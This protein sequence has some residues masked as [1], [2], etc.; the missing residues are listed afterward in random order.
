MTRHFFSR[1]DGS[2]LVTALLVMSLFMSLGVATLSL[3]DVQQKE[4]G[5]ERVRESAFALS[6]G[7]LNSQ[8]YLLSRQWPG[9][10]AQAYVGQC[11]VATSA[12]ARCPD[13]ATM[14]TGF[15]GSDYAAGMTWTTEVR[16]NTLTGTTATANFY[17][18]DAVRLQP[19]W[20]SNRDG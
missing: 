11:T 1:Q 20:D 15:T 12:N 4:S 16:D 8:I 18:D 6:E 7:V 19:Q 5:R 9:V 2:A 17:D 10:A 13:N 3:V 14:Q